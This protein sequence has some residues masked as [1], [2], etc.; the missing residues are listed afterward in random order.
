[1][2]SEPWHPTGGTSELPPGGGSEVLVLCWPF[3]GWAV[4]PH[5]THALPQSLEGSNRE[6]AAGKAKLKLPLLTDFIYLSF[7]LHHQGS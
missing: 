3:L 1:M 2:D 4:Q 5:P 6:K 7:P